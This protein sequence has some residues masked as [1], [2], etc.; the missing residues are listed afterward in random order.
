[1][2]VVKPEFTD[3]LPSCCLLFDWRCQCRQWSIVVHHKLN[4]ALR[5][6]GRF[7]TV[8]ELTYC[9]PDYF[10]PKYPIL[11]QVS[12]D[13]IGRHVHRGHLQQPFPLY[14]LSLDCCTS[15]S[16]L[17]RQQNMMCCR[18]LVKAL[19]SYKPMNDGIVVTPTVPL[20]RDANTP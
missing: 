12:D 10:C 13:F 14:H 19:Y 2:A 3:H 18:E 8:G 7:E 11:P 9:E 6:L 16:M 20:R 15:Q 17:A 1:M 5:H 4:W